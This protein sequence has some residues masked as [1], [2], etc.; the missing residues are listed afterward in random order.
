MPERMPI[1][2]IGES[3]R[4]PSRDFLHDIECFLIYY[5]FMRILENL[6]FGWVIL[7]L[8]FSAYRTYDA[9]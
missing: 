8:L 3:L 1:S 4:L 5:G 7:Y 2:P 6:P 9:F